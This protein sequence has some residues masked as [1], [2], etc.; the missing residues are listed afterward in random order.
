MA[1]S[2]HSG[3]QT[4][5]LSCTCVEMDSNFFVM[6]CSVNPISAPA[7][8]LLVNYISAHEQLKRF[9][10][11][12]VYLITIEISI[13]DALFQSRLRKFRNAPSGRS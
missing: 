10:I 6:L 8:A 13:V 12:G 1:L 4:V 11:G 2:K 3:L 9:E 7:A 5:D